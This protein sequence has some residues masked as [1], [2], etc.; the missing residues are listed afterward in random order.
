MKDN[1]YYPQV[2][3]MLRCLPLVSKETCFSLK[4][5]TAINLFVRDM[6]RLSVDIDLAYIPL[7]TREKS[8]ADVENALKRISTD[9]QKTIKS[10]QVHE[11]RNAKTKLI[12]KIFVR[13]E[14]TQ[15]KIEPNPVVRGS[16][17][18]SK[19]LSLV[20][21]A[22]EV[23][24]L[25]TTTSILSLPDLYGGK[26]VAALDRQHPRDLFDVKLLLETEGI[27]NEIRK[28]FVVYLGSHPRPMSEILNPNL[29][30]QKVAY[31][32][33]FV[34]MSTIPFTYEMFEETRKK[35]ISKIKSDL[36]KDEKTFLVSLQEGSPQWDKLKL[37]KIHELPA[38]KWKLENVQ[39]MSPAKRKLA[40]ELLQ[41]TLA[42]T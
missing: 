35:L 19:D 6:P 12:E 23:F 9:V 36:T 11:S 14:N 20:R 25:T 1:K 34:G 26:L 10:A 3:L 2:L 16:V 27:T 31:E 7:D 41:K 18:E 37:D 21:V 4:G 15:I 5:G 8:L 13:S 39:K 42:S 22:E 40:V 32:K 38:L 28:A 17:Y 33:E 29:S 30:D 24:E